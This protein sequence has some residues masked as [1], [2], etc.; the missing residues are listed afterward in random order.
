[1]NLNEYIKQTEEEFNKEFRAPEPFNDGLLAI[2]ADI[3][4]AFIKT[5][6]ERGVE[7]GRELENKEF[8]EGRRC[9]ICGEPKETNLASMC[10]NCFENA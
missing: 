6:I 5:R 10:D 4:L 2:K 7:L 8:R 1:M 3:L 9:D